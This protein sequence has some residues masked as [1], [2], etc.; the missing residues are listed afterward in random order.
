MCVNN[1]MSTPGYREGR[2]SNE[3]Y[4]DEDG[5]DG[6]GLPGLSVIWCLRAANINSRGT[7]A[8]NSNG[9]CAVYTIPCATQ[10]W[11]PPDD[12]SCCSCS[13]PLSGEWGRG[14]ATHRGR[15]TSF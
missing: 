8:L 15:V 7:L 12:L 10:R 2:V 3:W 13:G 6:V 9:C 5:V 14:V 4:G 11:S 1:T